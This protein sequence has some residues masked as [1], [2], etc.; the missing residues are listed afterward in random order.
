MTCRVTQP[1]SFSPSCPLPLDRYPAITLAHGGGGRLM[2]ELVKDMFLAAFDS[3]LAGARH[4]SAQLPKIDGPLAFTTDSFVVHPLEFPGGSIGALAVYGTANDLAMAGARPRYLSCGMI[5]EEGLPTDVLWRQVLEMKDAARLAGVEI[6]CGDTKVVERGKGDG[7]FINTSGLGVI[8][9][10]APIGPA[11][12]CPG[13]VVIVSG[14]IGRHGIAVMAAREELAFESSVD[15]DCG[16]LVDPVMDLIDAGI[17]VHCMRDL[18]RGGLA[19]ALNE[20]SEV[21]KL[22]VELSEEAITVTDPVRGACELLGLDPL[23]VANEG[24]FVAFVAEQDGQRALEVLRRHPISQGSNIVGTAKAGADPVSVS[25]RNPYGA[26]RIIDM[27]AGA[28]LP[29]IC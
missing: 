27:L 21:A 19:S 15:S 26:T 17:D 10:S 22:S 24:R 6:V 9:S 3:E 12:V 13:D 1:A 11:A 4:D 29:R 2:N 28:Q 20:I 14:D 7:L 5:L 23:Y 8:K 18:T 25:A 16:C